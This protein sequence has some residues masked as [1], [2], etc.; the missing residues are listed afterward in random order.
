MG[1]ISYIIG[2]FLGLRDSCRWGG[3]V[4]GFWVFRDFN[5]GSVGDF[6]KG[7]LDFIINKGVREFEYID[8]RYLLRVGIESL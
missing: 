1:G 6:L 8:I 4:D 2:L 5:E 7:Y 3:R